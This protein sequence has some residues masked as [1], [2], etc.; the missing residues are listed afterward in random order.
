MDAGPGTA[1]PDLF[2]DPGS[3]EVVDQSA[4]VLDIAHG[5]QLPSEQQQLRDRHEL[6]DTKH[7]VVTYRGIATTRFSE[8][9]TSQATFP[10]AGAAS[11]ETLDTGNPPQGVVPGSVKLIQLLEAGGST[12]LVEGVHY[13]VSAAEGTVTFSADDD[14]DDATEP[15]EASGD[16]VVAYLIPPVTRETAA[17]PASREV[18][19]PS[20]ARPVAP[21]VVD[22][23]PTFGWEQD[24]TA[25]G[26]TSTRRGNGL[27]IYLERPWWSSGAGEL[28]GVVVWPPADQPSPPELD[29]EDPLRPYVTQWGEDPVSSAG[30][31]SSRYPGVS[32]FPA[33]AASGAGYTLDEVGPLGPAVNVAGHPVDYDQ[34]R[35]LWYCDIDVEPGPAYQPFVR[36]A[37]ARYQPVSV[38]DAHLSCVVLAD[39]VQLAPDRF[40]TVVFDQ[41]D[42][43]TATITLSGPAPNA[44]E[45]AS[46]PGP[47][48]VTVEKRHQPGLRPRPR[49]ARGRPA[50]QAG[51]S[52]EQRPGNVDGDGRP[53]APAR[54]RQGPPRGR[55]VRAG[56]ARGR[57]QHPQ[58]VRARHGGAARVQ[59]AHR[60]V[61]KGVLR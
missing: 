5:D 24:S 54:A 42:P 13:V 50:G 2:G 40:A 21:K 4:F 45:V 52:G 44:T 35:D 41:S 51:P 33:A 16:I 48:R 57:R 1:D 46:E 18:A 31:L 23:L 34:A 28:L 9:F 58:P 27:R 39:F 37:L 17:P 26:A 7:R 6:G 60:A 30:A 38:P 10:Y 32:T 29:D 43:A 61:T 19:V 3:R 36:L 25:D 47:A 12:L 56:G 22:V 15:P 11:Q 55:A 20:S 14:G 49:L 59:R 8:Y 53:A